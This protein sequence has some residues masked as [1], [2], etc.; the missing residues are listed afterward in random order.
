M[1][2]WM[3]PMAIEVRLALGLTFGGLVGEVGAVAELPY[4]AKHTKCNSRLADE[5]RTDCGTS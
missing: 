1:K 5:Y 3:T 2:M 4:V